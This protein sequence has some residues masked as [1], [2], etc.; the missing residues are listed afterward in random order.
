MS[1]SHYNGKLAQKALLV[2]E[3]KVLVTRDSR[4]EQFEFPGGRLDAGE[5]PNQGIIREM[6]EE[7]GIQVSIQRILSLRKMFHGRDN[8]DMIFVFY[9][10]KLVDEDATFNVDPLEVAELQWVDKETYK[11]FEYFPLYKEVLENYF[12]NSSV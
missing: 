9:E 5:E 8:A 10:V 12:L 3:G 6:Q 1:E 11:N 4:D 2:K 7:L